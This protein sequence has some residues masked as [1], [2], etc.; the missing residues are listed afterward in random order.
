MAAP[1]S[2]RYGQ[3]QPCVLTTSRLLNQQLLAP[4]AQAEQ[5][6]APNS[7]HYRCWPDA[8]CVPGA[9][10]AHELYRFVDPKPRDFP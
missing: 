3:G 4:S 6:V 5:L 8:E 9:E 1:K 2:V 10:F 7:G